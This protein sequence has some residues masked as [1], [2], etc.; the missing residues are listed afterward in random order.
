M[1]RGLV[2][3]VLCALVV[4]AVKAQDIHRDSLVGVWTCKEAEIPSGVSISKEEMQ[5]VKTLQQGI[6]NSQFSFNTNSLFEWRF[7]AGAPKVFTELL[8]LNKQ[9]WSFDQQHNL[10][11]I[12]APK[13]NLM[14]ISVHKKHGA[15]YFII[16]DMPLLLR[17]EKE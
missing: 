14:Q 11:H 4:S 7:P 16:T 1:T 13:E 10:I 8:F 15:M 6:V 12:G 3:C 17:V 2:A 9:K 5:G